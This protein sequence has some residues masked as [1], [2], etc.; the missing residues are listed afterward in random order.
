MKTKINKTK[1][2]LLIT[3]ALQ[4][5][6]KLKDKPIEMIENELYEDLFI[7]SKHVYIGR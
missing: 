1:V 2:I 7:N 4:I 5:E 6:K 3:R